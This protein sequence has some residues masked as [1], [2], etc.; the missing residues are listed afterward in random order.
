MLDILITTAG[1]W[2]YP[3]KCIESIL[4]R[5]NGYVYPNGRR[6]PDG[7]RL[8]IQRQPGQQEGRDL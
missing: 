4:G 6:L 8:L 5:V 7:V 2:P 3:E 1:G